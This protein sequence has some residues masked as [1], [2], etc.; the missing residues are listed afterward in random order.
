MKVD[1]G[2]V[3]LPALAQAGIFRVLGISTAI[4]GQQIPIRL[5]RGDYGDVVIGS[6]NW[7]SLSL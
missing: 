5:E 6:G 7:K 3:L 2:H 4:L 1:E